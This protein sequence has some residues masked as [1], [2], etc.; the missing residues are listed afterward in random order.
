MF[1]HSL[2]TKILVIVLVFLTLIGAGFIS[3]S[4]STTRNYKLLHQEGIEGTLDYETEKVNKIIAQIERG[5]VFYG[6]GG[7]FCYQGQSDQFGEEFV[8]EGLPG[9]PEAVGGGFWFAP[10]EFSHN[11]QRAGF[12]AFYDKSRGT[13]RIDDSSSFTGYNYHSRDWY[14]EIFNSIERAH[15]GFSAQSSDALKV[16]WTKPYVDD[17]GSLSLMTSAGTGIFN[18][19]GKLIG[20]TTIDWEIDSI[21]NELLNIRPTKNSFVLLYEKEKDLV[22][23]CT[24]ENINSGD[25]LAA[26]P[27]DLNAESITHN[28][29]NYFCFKRYM[30]NNW[31]LSLYIPENEIAA[32]AERQNTRF[33]IWIQI[34]FLIMIVTAFFLI[35]RLINAP[36]KKL[37]SDVS[38]IALG[39]LDMKI[40]IKSRDEIGLLARTFNEM[41]IELKNSIEEN[42]REREEKKRINT[43]LAVANVIQ[44][45]ML[46]GNFFPE[47]KEFDIFGSMVPAK[48][49]G[50]DFY[51][52]YFIDENN[53][54]VVIADVSGKGIPA[55][56]FMVTAKTLIKN[57]SSC[58]TP[59]ASIESVNSKLCE[60]NDACIFVTAFMGIYNIPSKKF[61]YVNA[62]HNPPLIRKRNGS[63]EFLNT[64]PCFILAIKK[65]AVYREEVIQLEEGDSLFMYT[66]GVT[67]AMNRKKE[68]FCEKR[69]LDVLNRNKDVSP[70][71]LYAAVKNEV[72]AF[73]DGEEQTDDIAMLILKIT[74]NAEKRGEG[75]V[76]TIEARSENLGRLFD[77]INSEL[78][79]YSYSSEIKNQVNIAAEEIFINIADYAYEG[80]EGGVTISISANDKI[81][82]KFEDSGIPYN[83]LEYPDPEMEKPLKDRE[84]GGLGVYMFKKLMDKV[85]YTRCGDK[86]ILVITK[87]RK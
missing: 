59:K 83:P 32:D 57:C 78:D 49:V 36:I 1:I 39:N 48:E 67:E 66:D 73:A 7:K 85:E 33:I 31:S 70:K 9:I 16:V 26:I 53:L 40:N 5:A 75:T 23:S 29:M 56:L 65:D 18:D 60:N 68:L 74:D 63:F 69:L 10:N 61:F 25:S 13:V 81:S 42:L 27:W 45:S 87:E 20:I 24:Y 35:S 76:L 4:I 51:D 77:C 37:T 44:A 6:V 14:Q 84:I 54:A 58:R 62:G 34:S 8:I 2:R 30:D 86:N 12:Y 38:Q 21:I 17:S 50:G 11:R 19:D 28:E 22:I 80:R 64:K 71:E 3:Y 15:A 72:D 82:I 46:P 55:A 41:T 79:K 47:R 43:E 52:F